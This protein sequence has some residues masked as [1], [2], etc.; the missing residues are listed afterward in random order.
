[1]KKVAIMRPLLPEQKFISPYIQEIDK[2]RWYTN[3]GPLV[4]GFE[5]RL[6]EF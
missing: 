6:E 2:N 1:M 3:F 5:K 4:V